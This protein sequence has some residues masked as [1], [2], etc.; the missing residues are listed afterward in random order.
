VSFVFMIKLLLGGAFSFQ[1]AMH[2]GF[3][4]F[5]RVWCIGSVDLSLR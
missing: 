2:F 3:L 4:D 5:R 1:T